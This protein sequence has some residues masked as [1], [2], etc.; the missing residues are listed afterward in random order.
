[1]AW[2]PEPIWQEIG[3]LN[4][5]YSALYAALSLW[6][7]LLLFS[8]AA[9]TSGRSMDD[10]ADWV[11]YA[12][13]G[14]LL[15]ARLGYFALEIPKEFLAEPG[16]LLWHPGFS[17]HGAILGLMG[18]TA[19]FARQ[20]H[21][22]V[23]H[24][25][26]QLALAGAVAFLLTSF[27]SLMS[28]EVVGVVSDGPLSIQYPIYDEAVPVPPLRVPVFHLQCLWGMATVLGVWMFSRSAWLARQPAGTL[29][30]ATL[31]L[32][33]VGML[34]LDPLKEQKSHV[35]QATYRTSAVAADVACVILAAVWMVYLQSR[36]R[37][38]GTS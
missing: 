12:I 35:A 1:M 37:L 15:G 16:G 14:G 10:C 34:L 11:P 32:I 38:H 8:R 23:R 17:F 22:S 21:L 7:A 9:L 25:M 18:A 13:V 26:D 3:G 31:L 2:M 4:I 20:H 33:S 24:T 28:N 27:G 29:T 19:L 36:T 5:E 6:I 30:A